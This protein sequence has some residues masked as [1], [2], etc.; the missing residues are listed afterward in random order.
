MFNFTPGIINGVIVLWTGFGL[1]RWLTMQYDDWKEP[2]TIKRFI[3]FS[4]MCGPIISVLHVMIIIFNKSK[5][6]REKFKNYY[7]R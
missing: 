2:T 1:Y 5:N 3:L 4:L 6:L 7:N